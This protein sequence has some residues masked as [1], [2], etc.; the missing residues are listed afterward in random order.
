MITHL[1]NVAELKLDRKCYENYEYRREII[2]F[3]LIII[4][5]RGSRPMRPAKVWIEEIF[6]IATTTTQIREDICH[7][8][9]EIKMG[10]IHYENRRILLS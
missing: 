8:R 5:P 2:D 3:L 9:H 6:G 4:D 7:K 1:T 10:R